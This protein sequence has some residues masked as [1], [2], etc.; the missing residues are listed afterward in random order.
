MRGASRQRSARYTSRMATPNPAPADTARPPIAK[1]IAPLLALG[2]YLAPYRR[3][4]ILAGIALIVAA[5]ATLVFPAAGRLAIDNGFTAATTARA[6]RYFVG[7]MLVFVVLGIGSASRFYLVTW[8]GERV[9]AD[10]RSRVY[11]HILSLSPVFFETTRT[12]EVLS[13]LAAD[14]TLVQTVVGSSASLALR[15]I[16]MSIGALVLMAI[17]SPKLTGLAFVS[18]PILLGLIMILGRRV[19][20]LSRVA[21]DRLAD[22][23]ALAGETI[24]AIQTVQAYTHEQADRTRYRGAV[25]EA[26]ASAIRRT[27]TRAFMTAMVIIVGGAF[28]VGVLWV[29]RSDVVAGRLTGGQFAQFL[30]YAFFLGGSVGAL[31]EI[32]GD[33]QRAAG[34]TERLLEIL[35]TT[36]AVRAPVQPAAL[37]EPVSGRVSFQQVDF[38]YPSR[39]DHLALHE[40]NLTVEPGEAIALVGP[41]GAGKST[42]FQ[43][44]QR[45]YD[46]TAGAICIDGVSIETLQP[47]QLRAHIAVV[48]QEPVM[49]AGTIADNIRYGRIDASEPEIHAAA[50][51]AAA[52]EFIRRLPNG[53]DTNLGER[54][55]TLSV[56]QRQRIAIARAI[57][58]DAAVL[59]LDEATSALDAEN[60][61]LVQLGLANLM[62]GNSGRG[63]TTL[64]IAHRL[65]TIQKLRRIVVMNH[66]RIVAEGN[67]AE[68]VRAGGLYARLAALQFDESHAPIG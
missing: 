3:M 33:L 8:I 53:Y 45:F 35:N 64:V 2:P 10:I 14:T 56:G 67:H 7:L 29:G 44:L 11:S 59:L 23:S 15:S 42:V 36:P 26:F 54:G 43:L 24:N 27:R 19:R 48:S 62:A 20:G 28:L 40:F 31:T 57:L 49:F 18:V 17:T 4:I 38:T 52:N 34:A 9:V 16:V 60:E 58:R 1:R 12:G 50:E 13:R 46:P 47:E 61:H 37:P 63:R 21:Q 65:A 55:I 25:E 66:G 32:W 30:I 51:A 41:S 68:L 5:S 22:T 6:G 39:P